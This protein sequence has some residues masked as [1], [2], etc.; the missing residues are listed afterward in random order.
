MCN[1][2]IFVEM[3][4]TNS[5]TLGNFQIPV[6]YIFIHSFLNDSDF[7]N[8]KTVTLTSVSFL[9]Y[10]LLDLHPNTQQL[11]SIMIS[12]MNKT[13]CSSDPVPTRLLMSHIHAIVPILPHIV[14]LCLTTGDFPFSCKSYVII[15]NPFD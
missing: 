4:D 11:S 1:H 7:G 15:C 13:T 2:I 10:W 12:C 6:W 3:V 14:N 9:K 5:G 8:E